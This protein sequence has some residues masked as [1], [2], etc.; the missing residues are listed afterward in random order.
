MENGESVKNEE[1][2]AEQLINLAWN[3]SDRQ[4]EALVKLEYFLMAHYAYFLNMQEDIGELVDSSIEVSG[5]Y[6]TSRNLLEELKESSES[7]SKGFQASHG[8]V[9]HISF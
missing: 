8:Q 9:K 7:I 5:F 6:L 2:T 1:L 4:H 3:A